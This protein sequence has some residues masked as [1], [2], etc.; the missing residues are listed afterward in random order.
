MSARTGFSVTFDVVTPES[1]EQ[2]D[3]ADSGF[4]VDGVSLRDAIAALQGAQVAPSCEPFNPNYRY[5]WFYTMDAEVNYRTGAEETRALHLP[6]NLTPSTRRRIA[7][8]LGV[9]S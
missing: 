6:T 1:A 2:G 8:L 9:R 5:T 7:R 4:V 3:V